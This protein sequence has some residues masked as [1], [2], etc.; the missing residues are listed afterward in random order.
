VTYRA[1]KFTAKDLFDRQDVADIQRTQDSAAAQKIADQSREAAE[2]VYEGA[3]EVLPPLAYAVGAAIAF[4]LLCIPLVLILRFI[5]EIANVI[6]AIRD[7]VAS[8]LA[9]FQR[10]NNDPDNDGWLENVG[11]FFFGEAD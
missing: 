1:D 7:K 10:G 5:S 8:L 2:S 4:G 11:D 9:I 3:T 6:R